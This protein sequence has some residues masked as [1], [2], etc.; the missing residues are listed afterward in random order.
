M[1]YRCD[2][3]ICSVNVSKNS[4]C[5]LLTGQF[6]LLGGGTVI[7][8]RKALTA[9]RQ[10]LC[11]YRPIFFGLKSSD[12]SFTVN[13]KLNSDGLDSSRRKTGLDLLPKEG[14]YLVADDSVK[15]TSGLLRINK[16]NVERSRVCDSFLNGAF[17]YLVKGYS[18][19]LFGIK[20]EKCC[21]MPTDRFAFAIGVGRE[22]NFFSGLR[23]L[24]KLVDYLRLASY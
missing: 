22:I 4:V 16:I 14:A 5:I 11:V 13:N 17:G 23:L 8:R 15:N 12:L 18:Y 3:E 1:L 20:S 10:K 24:L 21:Q 9:K 7:F 2:L 19:I 6:D